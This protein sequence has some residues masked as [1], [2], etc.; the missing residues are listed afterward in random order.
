MKILIISTNPLPASPSGPAYVAGALRAAG[1][2]VRAFERLFAGDLRNDLTAALTDFEPDVVGVSIR[3][4]FGDSL[5]AGVPYGTRHTDLRPGIRE[6]VDIVRAA[7]R[8][9]IVLGGPGFNYYAADWLEYL[10][11][12]YGIRGEGEQSFPEFLKRLEQGAATGDIPGCVTRRNGQ[13]VQ[14]PPKPVE[15]LNAAPL[16]AYDLFDLDRHAAKG[17]T[18]AILTKR[19]CALNCI[20]CPYSRLEGKHYRLKTPERILAEMEHIREHSSCR[21]VMF[22]D[23]NFNVPGSH[24]A[25]ICRLLS[26]RAAGMQWGT[27]DLRPAGVTPEFVKLMIDSGCFYL[28]L[29]I[30]SASDDMLRRLKRGYTAGQVRHALEA[31]DRSGFRYGASLMLG[32]PGETPETI[33]ETLRVLDDYAIPNGVWVTIGIYMW[34]DLQPFV[35]EMRGRGELEGR[36]LFAGQVYGSPA[37]SRPFLDDL[38]VELRSKA[39]YQVQVNHPANWYPVE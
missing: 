13:V 35:A 21:R 10:D 26:T 2:E 1:H 6:I 33:R 36:D 30:E 19:G 29:A 15:D 3:L 5:D 38:L 32:A 27:G 23:N 25:A 37:L 31:L 39:G 9:V 12:E 7:S 17:I 16:P 18:P 11:L 14:T 8:A 22:C 24:A 28:N 34:T 20:Y 4:V